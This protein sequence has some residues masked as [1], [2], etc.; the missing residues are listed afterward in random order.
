M[1]KRLKRFGNSETKLFISYS[2]RKKGQVVVSVNLWLDYID[3]INSKLVLGS[4]W[5]WRGC[6]LFC[7]FQ[8]VEICGDL[9]QHQQGCIIP[10]REKEMKEICDKTYV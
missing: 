7:Q 8:H 9:D 4:V 5:I 3:L 6:K 2:N 1:A 10:E